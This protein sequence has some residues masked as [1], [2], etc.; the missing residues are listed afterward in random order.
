MVSPIAMA[1]LRSDPRHQAQMF[2]FQT[3]DRRIHRP[4]HPGG[5]LGDGLHDRLQIGGRARDHPQDLGR[6]RLLL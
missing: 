3:E 1:V 4:A 6:G 5:V 2:P